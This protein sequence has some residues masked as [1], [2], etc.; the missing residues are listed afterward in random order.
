MACGGAETV[1]PSS[2]QLVVYRRDRGAA[3]RGVWYPWME[4][5][6]DGR[7]GL[8]MEVTSADTKQTW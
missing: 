1:K 4:E 8:D 7:A 6:R 5:P 2:L 3:W